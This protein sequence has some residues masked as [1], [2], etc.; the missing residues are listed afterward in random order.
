MDDVNRG[1]GMKVRRT[2][3]G[4]ATIDFVGIVARLAMIGDERQVAPQAP[5][6]RLVQP[7]LRQA[8]IQPLVEAF[9]QFVDRRQPRDESLANASSPA[10]RSD[11]GKHGRRSGRPRSR[12]CQSKAATFATA[13]L[14]PIILKN[15]VAIFL[16]I[17]RG[18]GIL[19]GS[20]GSLHG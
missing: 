13:V 11:V 14:R 1:I 19:L 2:A 7:A 6:A 8:G 18:D 12:M 17:L 15:R 20:H 9:F 10:R 5:A 16:D 4:L 3:L